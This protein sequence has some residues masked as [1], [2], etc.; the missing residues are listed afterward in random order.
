MKVSLAVE[1]HGGHN[2]EVACDGGWA[3]LGIAKE[4]NTLER[5]LWA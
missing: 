5:H 2:G 3:L 1:D 4:L